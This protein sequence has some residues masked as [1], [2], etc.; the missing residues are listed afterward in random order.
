MRNEIVDLIV[1]EVT[2]LFSRVDQLFNVVVLVFQ[3]QLAI[4]LTARQIPLGRDP[5]ALIAAGAVLGHYGQAET[6]EF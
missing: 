3:S 2:F 4:P 1:G 6:Y 5:V